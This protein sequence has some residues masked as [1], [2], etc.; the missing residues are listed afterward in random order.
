MNIFKQKK[1][2]E[3]EAKTILCEAL[4]YF[5]G[6]NG[7]DRNRRFAHTQIGTESRKGEVKESLCKRYVVDCSVQKMMTSEFTPEELPLK[8]RPRL[9]A[10]PPLPI[11]TLF[12]VCQSMTKTSELL[13]GFLFSN[14]DELGI[15]DWFEIEDIAKEGEATEGGSVTTASAAP[16]RKS[17]GEKWVVKKGQGVQCTYVA[18]SKK[19][20]FLLEFHD[21]ERGP[22]VT[23]MLLNDLGDDKKRF[24]GTPVVIRKAMEGVTV[25]SLRDKRIV[26]E[27][28]KNG[29]VVSSTVRGQVGLPPAPEEKKWTPAFVPRP[30]RR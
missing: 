19:P 17:E 26:K 21:P 12:I 22:A 18:T 23:S 29:V 13:S 9:E 15:A 24:N 5:I 28:I 6:R 3:Q 8:K 14:R 4:E 1:I 16:L 2:Y 20:Y 30:P 7:K 27:E 10:T 11:T 25:Q